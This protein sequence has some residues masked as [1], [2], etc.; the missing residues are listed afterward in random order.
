[1]EQ[2]S[3]RQDCAVSTASDEADGDVCA[4]QQ[5]EEDA[6]EDANA[7]RDLGVRAERGDRVGRAGDETDHDD[8]R[9]LGVA[10]PA[11]YWRARTGLVRQRR[12]DIVGR[13]RSRHG[14]IRAPWW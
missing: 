8:Q 11:S 6:D 12:I 4:Q 2:C 5:G 13:N 10:P 3:Q 1:V 14:G 9:Q 7:G